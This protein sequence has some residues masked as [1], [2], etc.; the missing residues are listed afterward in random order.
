ME[1]CGWQVSKSIDQKIVE[2]RFDNSNFEKNVKESMSTLDKL[3]EKLNMKGAKD[4]IE[5][6]AAASRKMNFVESADGVHK[7]TMRFDA[8]YALTSKIFDRLTDKALNL[9][10]SMSVDQLSAGFRKYEEKTAAVQTIMSATGKSIDEVTEQLEI[11]NWFS[12]ETS[13]SFTDMASN[14]GKFTSAGVELESAVNAMQG[15]ATWAA[16]SGQNTQAASR[17]MYNLSQAM[18]VGYVSLMDWKSIENANMGTLAFKETVLETAAAHTTYIKALGKNEQGIKEYINT[19]NGATYTALNFRE[20]LSDKWFTRDILEIAL[21]EYGAYA[22]AIKMVQ[23]RLEI[24]TASQTMQ[25]VDQFIK[26]KE[27]DG[28][29]ESLHEMASAMSLTEE[30]AAAL[31]ETYNTVGKEA[32]QAA[33]MAKTWSDVVSATRDAVS[34]AWMNLFETIFGDFNDAKALFTDMANELWDVFAGPVANLADE[35]SEAMNH[36]SAWGLVTDILGGEDFMKSADDW[37]KALLKVT[38]GVKYA[39]GTAL[40]VDD[41]GN[42][43]ESTAYYS[44]QELINRFGSLEKVTERGMLTYEDYQNALAELGVSLEAG[45][46]EATEFEEALYALTEK[47]GRIKLIESLG[48]LYNA[49]KKVFGAISERFSNVFNTPMSERIS[50]FIDRF[51]DLS[52]SFEV[53][54][55]AAERITVAFEGVFKVLRLALTIVSDVSRAIFGLGAK[56]LPIIGRAAFDIFETVSKYIGDLAGV[57]N[58]AIDIIAESITWL[59]DE[60]KNSTLYSYI[61]TYFGKIKEF[62]KGIGE[63]ISIAIG[64]DT[65]KKLAELLLNVGGFILGLG[66]LVVESEPVQKGLSTITGA[67]KNFAAGIK[68]FRMPTL[69]EITEEL[70]MFANTLKIT[71]ISQTG[72]KIL[73]KVTTE[74][75]KEYAKA[76]DTIANLYADNKSILV[77]A[78]NWLIFIV[79][80]IA[81]FVSETA[82]VSLKSIYVATKKIIQLGQ[83]FAA[84]KL[85]MNGADLLKTL[86]GKLKGDS[87]GGGFEG[88]MNGLTNFVKALGIFMLEMGAF[89]YLVGKIP[90]DVAQKGLERFGT[91]VGGLVAVGGILLAA[92]HGLGEGDIKGLA[93]T[94]AALGFAIKLIV[95]ALVELNDV[96]I[97]IGGLVSLGVVLAGFVGVMWALGKYAAGGGLSAALP[98]VALAQGLKMLLG[99]IKD[100]NDFDWAK[101]SRGLLAMFLMMIPVLGIIKIIGKT[102]KVSP[103]VFIGLAFSLKM[104]ASTIEDL[105][106]LGTGVLVKGAVVM[107]IMLVLLKKYIMSLATLSAQVGQASGSIGK[108][109]IFV[110]VIAMMLALAAGIAIL[111]KTPVKQLIAGIAAVTIIAGA[112][113]A[114]MWAMGQLGTAKLANVI[115]SVVG[116]GIIMAA[117]VILFKEALKIP[118]PQKAIECMAALSIFTAN[119]IV[120]AGA[121]ALLSKIDP[122]TFGKGVKMLYEISGFLGI[123][124][125]VF[126][127]LGALDK[128]LDGKV[129]DSL[130]RGTQMIQ[131]LGSAIGGF[132][133]GIVGGF[134]GAD[135]E[136]YSSHLPAIGKNLARFASKF[137]DSKDLL[138]TITDEN[139]SEKVGNFLE[140]LNEFIVTAGAAAER[141][142][143][144]KKLPEVGGYLQGF[145]ANL[146]KNGKFFAGLAD[147]SPT[148]IEAAKTVAQVIGALEPISHETGGLKSLWSGSVSFKGLSTN[149]D[150]YVGAIDSFANK[151]NSNTELANPGLAD[152]IKRFR[153]VSIEVIDLFNKLPNEGGIIDQFFSGNKNWLTVS[154]N[155]GAF[156]EMITRFVTGLA[157]AERP[158]TESDKDKIVKP[159]VNVASSVITLFNSLP[160]DGGKWAE[161]FGGN[162]D[163]NIVGEN[164]GAFVEAIKNFVR[165]VSGFGDNVDTSAIETNIR[166]VIDSINSSIE[167]ASVK[168]EFTGIVL[169]SQLMGG[170]RDTVNEQ[171]PGIVEYFSSGMLAQFKAQEPKYV[172]IGTSII[173]NLVSGMKASDKLIAAQSA[174]TAVT[175]GVA[176]SFGYGSE[177]GIYTKFYSGGQY[178]AEGLAAGM[179]SWYAQSIVQSAAANL[180]STAYYAAKDK[181]VINSPSKLFAKLGEGTAEGYNL[182]V[183]NSLGS[184]SKTVERM[185]D[186]SYDSLKQAMS[187]ISTAI[188]TDESQPVI[189]PILDLSDVNSGINTLT[190]SSYGFGI[191]ATTRNLSNSIKIQNG[192]NSVA[193]AISSLK[194]DLNAMKNEMTGMKIVM[195]SGALVGSISTK[196][197]N[198]L[199]TISNYKGRGNL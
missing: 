126:T 105:G 176:L 128:L 79:K 111:G 158:I 161:W 99:V 143:D 16:I 26:Q 190:S 36:K 144:L 32:F 113:T 37:E 139:A 181:L 129:M 194:D 50:K 180:G 156:R 65:G 66:G 136:V 44:L 109:T 89:I 62:F 70:A 137:S 97:N 56:V 15:I 130:H 47:G 189:R 60:F 122:V 112:V 46:D 182:G 43:T 166:N 54:D 6:V 27:I 96:R 117:L 119:A 8:M 94:I 148:Q 33:Q 2:M 179:K 110:G 35:M 159:F 28:T 61:N 41:E 153:D 53:T 102:D 14:V 131:E 150:G 29:V 24:D 19:L 123:L 7:L 69:A 197:D 146:T 133:G 34:S 169:G 84:F 155:L 141:N 167:T 168:L 72:S 192:G 12:D 142:E 1:G 184:V 85:M 193:N 22:S 68:N 104:I 11:L 87:S 120:L 101:N 108:L 175:A 86:N 196:M 18:G 114:I 177:K 90:D 135:A 152:K 58:D 118:D 80:R 52:K 107:G 55:D 64:P 67:V 5:D 174:S 157:N 178:A 49:V 160:E 83:M 77:K 20:T 183:T 121:A 185:G 71:D 124:G 116:I 13:Y 9:V 151:L 30:E 195:D 81:T 149:L 10:K 21:N 191:G 51:H 163:W 78:L 95:D 40:M 106:S 198:A 145:M 91:V 63:S 92:S 23:D 75:T 42:L 162:K 173:T 98:L 25:F 82:K 93:L 186:V 170:F 88:A 164:L 154:R 125:G 38:D 31:Y 187:N 4:S 127:A 172:D 188:N 76:A 132:F 134:K 73:G 45:T 138:D 140:T 48:A 199:G 147:V 165:D 74:A 17:A 57:L 100:Y 39:Y 171:Y 3:K 103:M 59:I 115:A